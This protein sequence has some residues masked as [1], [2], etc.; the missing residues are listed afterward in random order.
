[1]AAI[2]YAMWLGGAPWGDI[3]MQTE[4]S[5]VVDKGIIICFRASIPEECSIFGDISPSHPTPP[6]ASIVSIH[7]C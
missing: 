1:M 4:F 2:A 5:L 3:A 6:G 7:H